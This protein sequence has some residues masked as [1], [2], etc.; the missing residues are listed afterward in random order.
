MKYIL[1]LFFL[2]TFFLCKS[3]NLISVE[4][5]G[6][7]KFYTDLQTSIDSAQNGDNVFVPAGVFNE[8][9]ISKRLNIYGTGTNIDSS[10]ALGTTVINNNI[11]FTPASS[12][13][14]LNGIRCSNLYFGYNY[15]DIDNV[16]ILNCM[17]TGS[18]IGNEDP[19]NGNFNNTLLD[20]IVIRNNIIT[21][22][23]VGISGVNNIISNNIIGGS[24]NNRDATNSIIS[25]NIFTNA[26]PFWGLFYSSNISNN[27]FMSDTLSFGGYFYSSYSQFNNVSN[28]IFSETNVSSNCCC[29]GCTFTNNHTGIS[30][31]P[32]FQS[33]PNN[34][35]LI[36]PTQF[37]GNDG[38]Q[39]GIYGGTNP[40]KDGSIPI[41][42]HIYFKQI[43]GQTGAGGL[44]PVQIKV[45]AQNN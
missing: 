3:Q 34:L 19:I 41:N 14:V 1:T 40:W 23:I 18:I 20:N 32:L 37:I 29:T 38:T 25:N 10:S 5:N 27:I 43:G 9:T 28:N 31:Q 21:G 12:F 39:V 16:T 17:I 33:F 30:T 36:N 45:K 15:Q 26:S 13:T 44:L 22:S 24:F 11:N 2:A 35:H 7:S 4:H 6:V 8:I 42:P